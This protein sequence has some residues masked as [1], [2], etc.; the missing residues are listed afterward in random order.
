MPRGNQSR[1]HGRK[2]PRFHGGCDPAPQILSA[3]MFNRFYAASGGAHHFG[4]CMSTT[5]IPAATGA[6]TAA[7][8]SGHKIFRSRCSSERGPRSTEWW[9][10]LLIEERLTAFARSQS[11]PA[12][13]VCSIPRP[14]LIF[15]VTPG[16]RGRRGLR[17]FFLATEH[18]TGRSSPQHFTLTRPP[19]FSVVGTARA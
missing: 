14:A 8:A 18:D 1:A 9:A 5:S 17:S 10:N 12:G 6:G 16:G 11:L 13:T 4:A 7:F 15:L 19:P 3:P 2:T